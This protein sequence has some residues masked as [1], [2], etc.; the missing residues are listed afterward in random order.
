MIQASVATP[1]VRQQVSQIVN[2]IAPNDWCGQAYAVRDWL[3][4]KI[5][6]MRDPAGVELLHTP[7]WLL[8]TI[9]AQGAAQCDCDDVAI[10]AGALM[11]AIGW[12]VTLVVVAFLDAS[13]FSHIY[14][15][16][17]APSPAFVDAQGNP[18]WIEFDTTRPM[19]EL[20]VNL[21]SR[22]QEYPVL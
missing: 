11:G 17:S 20:P 18:I 1:L 13:A 12:S 22:S 16:A 19:Q 10:L 14:C 21:I 8:R 4:D 15:S 3:S 9:N 7:E 2:G 5:Q 6:F